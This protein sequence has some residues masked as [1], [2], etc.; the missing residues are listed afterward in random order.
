MIG[1]IVPNT[2]AQSDDPYTPSNNSMIFEK[3]EIVFDG[4]GNFLSDVYVNNQYDF[5]L[6]PP[7]EWTM[8][9]NMELY[10]QGE[11][12]VVSFFSN[13]INS[14]FTP[15][16]MVNYNDAGSSDMFNTFRS[17]YSD[18]QFLDVISSMAL[19]NN[20]NAVITEKNIESFIDGYKTTLQFNDTINDNSL[21]IQRES[22]NFIMKNGKTYSFHFFSPSSIFDENVMIS[23]KVKL[24]N[25][26]SKTIVLKNKKISNQILEF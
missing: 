9:E 25:N 1:M 18:S 16:F 24:I 10:T 2:F 17:T 3:S 26:S 12:N 8:N 13:E 14:E 15:A 4:N 6:I 21:D 19:I 11:V 22:I 23:G 20:S 5:L 7:Q